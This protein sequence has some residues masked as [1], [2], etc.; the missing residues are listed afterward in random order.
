MQNDSFSYTHCVPAEYSEV[1]GSGCQPEEMWLNQLPCPGALMVA[2]EARGSKRKKKKVHVSRLSAPPGGRSEWC[3]WLMVRR[4]RTRKRRRGMLLFFSALWRS[5]A[6]IAGSSS[7][8]TGSRSMRFPVTH[9]HIQAWT[10]VGGSS[11]RHLGAKR[12]FST[13]IQQSKHTLLSH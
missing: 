7:I 10:Q 13:D 1:T 3:I 5:G 4:R 8:R 9:T 11:T 2:A 6:K 12:D